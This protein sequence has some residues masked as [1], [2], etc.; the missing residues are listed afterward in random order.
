LITHEPAEIHIDQRDLD[1]IRIRRYQRDELAR[2]LRLP[3]D[4]LTPSG[5][6]C[7]PFRNLAE[8]A[9]ES[10]LRSRMFSES[11]GPPLAELPPEA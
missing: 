8:A 2:A 6:D 3:P 9:A 10:V 5:R 11:F 4:K 7:S 1:Y